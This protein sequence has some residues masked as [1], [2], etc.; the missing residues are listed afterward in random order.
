MITS[1]AGSA[2]DT[3]VDERVRY[4]NSFAH[5]FKRWNK[6]RRGYQRRL[7]EIYRFLIPPGMRVLE[8]GCGTGDL[9][10]ALEPSYGV[11][12]DL[13]PEMVKLARARHP[14]LS[15]VEDEG[16]GIGLLETFDYI[17]FADVVNE[18]WD[19]RRHLNVRLHI[20]T[21]P[22]ESS[23]IRIVDCGSCREAWPKR[24]VSSRGSFLKTG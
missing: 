17:V 8:I 15:F 6:I 23:S 9:L 4:W 2:R 13:S 22:P 14:N 10:A 5:E 20:A 24:S 18:M 7:T 11:G 19:V 12:V 1:A 3:Y 21:L 16:Q